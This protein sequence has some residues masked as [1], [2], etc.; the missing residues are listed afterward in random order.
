MPP[1]LKS[2]PGFFGHGLY[3]T[4]YPRYIQTS[5]EI[6]MGGSEF[7]HIVKPS[8]CFFRYS[9]YYISGFKHFAEPDS[10][11]ASF[12]M[13]FV[14][15]GRPFPVTEIRGNSTPLMGKHCN[16]QSQCCGGSGHHDSHY[17]SVKRRGSA[18]Y[19]CRSREEPDYDEIVVFN[20]HDVLPV[21]LFEFKRRR[22]TLLWLDD[23]Y[24]SQHNFW[25]LLCDAPECARAGGIEDNLMRQRCTL[26][27]HG[28]NARL[29]TDATN[30]DQDVD[31]VLFKNAA[32]MKQF[33]DENTK[34]SKC[35][36]LIR[37]IVLN[38][39]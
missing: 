11:T 28:L 39:F 3:F 33:L 23:S 37:A 5:D 24:S 15:C 31:V 19:P 26:C 8:H 34:L 18:Y 2:D 17:V 9:D 1:E 7:C 4:R 25:K 6:G 21:A 32:E 16:E 30:I 14:A 22:R 35:L 10:T 13:S 36:L 27:S 20:T 12:L 38:S 29:N